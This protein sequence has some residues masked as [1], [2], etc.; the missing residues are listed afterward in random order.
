MRYYRPETVKEVV[1][2]LAEND[3]YRCL[4]GGQ[5]LVAM[6]NADLV[7]PAGL[8]SLRDV[9]E[10]RG[11]SAGAAA[12]RVGAMTTH[13]ELSSATELIGASQL[14]R[15]AAER[16][17][18]PGVRAR[19]TIGGSISHADPAADL[20]S[21]LVALD[22]DV[23]I[24][25]TGGSRILKARDFFVG[26]YTTALELGEMVAAI[27]VKQEASRSVGVY[28]KVRRA[29]GDFATTSVAFRGEFVDGQCVSASVAVGGCGATPIWSHEASAL[30]VGARPGDKRIGEA[31]ELLVEASDPIDDIRGSSNY[32][33][34]LIRRILP[35]VFR[36]ASEMMPKAE[37]N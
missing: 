7:Q 27:H 31:A 11:V 5:T 36:E 37:G 14:L 29:K 6:L 26:Y 16:I 15:R 18:H 2:L 3:G 10:L 34:Q 23:E 25:G 12:V 19:G 13:A 32:R 33:R 28:R 20:P 35:N 30:L 24:A 21:A 1:G 22:A 17:G 9:S 8:I 4:A